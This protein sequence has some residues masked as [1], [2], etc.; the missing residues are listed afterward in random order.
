MT[1]HLRSR[2]RLLG[3]RA[4]TTY[5]ETT[6]YTLPTS[7]RVLIW[8]RRSS[9]KQLRKR[10]QHPTTPASLRLS[11]MSNRRRSRQCSAR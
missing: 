1:E 8:R 11:P 4:L 9:C 7:R 6:A 5:T 2:K 10:L 3:R